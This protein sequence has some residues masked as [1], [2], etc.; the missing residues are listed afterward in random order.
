MASRP[1]TSSLSLEN[2]ESRLNLSTLGGLTV[3]AYSDMPVRAQER[4]VMNERTA[5]RSL[6]EYAA[7]V[8]QERKGKKKSR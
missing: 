1:N 5:V 3:P 2:L 7:P 6:S 4:S 8:K